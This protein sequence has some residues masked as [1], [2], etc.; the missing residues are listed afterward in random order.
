MSVLFVPS[1]HLQILMLTLVCL[2]V[3]FESNDLKMRSANISVYF[4]ISLAMLAES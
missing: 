4:K 2:M 3:N 1:L